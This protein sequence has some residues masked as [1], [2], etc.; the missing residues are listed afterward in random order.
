[1]TPL[2]TLGFA[3]LTFMALAGSGRESLAQP[4]ATPGRPALSPYL[5]LLRS[6]GSPTLNYYGLVRPE[7][8]GRQAIQAVQSA[9]AANQRTIGD[10]LNGGG[11]PVTGI[12][13][14]FQNHRSYFLNQGSGGAGGFGVGGGRTSF[15]TGGGGGGVG[16]GGGFGG[17]VGGGGRR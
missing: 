2:K 14:Q 9:E 15:A 13:S 4:G 5:N 1:M 17:A 12:A 6:G 16:G 7:F 3:C 8:N 11:L 10:L